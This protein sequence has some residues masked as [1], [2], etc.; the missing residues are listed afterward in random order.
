MTSTRGASV[1]LLCWPIVYDVAQRQA[2]EHQNL[3]AIP[4]T[5]PQTSRNSLRSSSR[6]VS[7]RGRGLKLWRLGETEEEEEEEEEGKAEAG[8]GVKQISGL[9]QD[10]AGVQ[11]AP[12]LT[13]TDRAFSLCEYC[14]IQPLG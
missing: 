3:R 12:R 6:H 10:L 5:S 8:R 13:Q 14:A 4:I 2:F 11:G 7:S 9:L 1:G